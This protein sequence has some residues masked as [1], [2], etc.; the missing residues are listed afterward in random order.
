MHRPGVYPQLPPSVRAAQRLA[1][2][3][4]GVPEQQA[5][6]VLRASL[7]GGE[8]ASGGWRGSAR[9]GRRWS[10]PRAPAPLWPRRSRRSR[11]QGWRLQAQTSSHA[12]GDGADQAISLRA[13]EAQD[14][15]REGAPPRE[16][17]AFRARAP[18]R[19]LVDADGWPGRR[20]GREH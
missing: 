16:V 18:N 10:G 8:A 12:R 11:A 4:R 6:R 1:P 13:R 20:R 19:A 3:R 2:I 17:E 7:H 14:S 5:S 15:V 9:G